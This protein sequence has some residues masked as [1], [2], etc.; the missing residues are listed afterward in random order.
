NIPW[1][2]GRPDCFSSDT[3]N[4]FKNTRRGNRYGPIKISDEVCKDILRLFNS[5]PELELANTKSKNGKLITYERAFA[6]SYHQIYDITEAQL[7]NIITGKRNVY[8]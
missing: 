6:K 3:I 1:N 2:K 8:Q 5:R 7:C 4:K